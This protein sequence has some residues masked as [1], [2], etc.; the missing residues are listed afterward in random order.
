MQ[1]KPH[2]RWTVPRLP[3]SAAR[4]KVRRPRQIV[5]SDHDMV[6]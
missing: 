4:G 5:E 3:L 1:H 6:D 2:Q